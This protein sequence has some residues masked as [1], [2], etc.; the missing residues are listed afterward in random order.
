MHLQL[1]SRGLDQDIQVV[2]PE[3]S[4]LTITTTESSTLRF[5]AVDRG[6]MSLNSE[7]RPVSM[8]SDSA[9]YVGVVIVVCML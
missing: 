3:A 6:Y 8:V 1:I 2:L 9:V 7:Y 4:T 5:T